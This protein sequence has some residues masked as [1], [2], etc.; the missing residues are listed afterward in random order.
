MQGAENYSSDQ[1]HFKK[2]QTLKEIFK[3][4]VLQQS[5]NNQIVYKLR[6]SYNSKK[7]RTSLSSVIVCYSVLVPLR[8]DRLILLMMCL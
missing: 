5:Q 4:L 7:D 3:I 8:W 2:N 6:E 1:I